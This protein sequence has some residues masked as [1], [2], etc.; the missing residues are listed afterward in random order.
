MVQINLFRP[1]APHL[2]PAGPAYDPEEDEPILEEAWPHLRIVYKFFLHFLESPSFDTRSAQQALSVT[3]L[4]QLLALF[5]SED[6]R[7]R[8]YLK[9]TLHRLYGRFLEYRQFIRQ[10][11]CNIFYTFIYETERHNGIAELLEILGTI[12]HGFALPLKPEHKIFLEKALLPLHKVRGCGTF[13]PQMAYCVFQFLEK[14]PTLTGSIFKS[15]LRFWP[16]VNSP[17]E[18]MFLSEIE[19]LLAIVIPE[20]IPGVL[21]P[22]FKRL[23]KCMGS[24]HFQ[25]AE[26]ALCLWRKKMF[27]K[28]TRRHLHV[29]LPIVYAPLYT[30]SK[31]HWHRVV[32]SMSLNALRLFMEMDTKLFTQCTEQYR[33]DFSRQTQAKED[34][35]KKWDELELVVSR[36]QKDDSDAQRLPDTVVNTKPAELG[37]S[38]A[39][40]QLRLRRK[41]LLP[42]DAQTLDAL[43]NHVGLAVDPSQDVSNYDGEDSDEDDESEEEDDETDDGSSQTDSDDTE[44]ESDDSD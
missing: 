19:E 39:H 22:L 27:M 17:K 15:I 24:P 21:A 37:S 33:R 14:D 25:V 10:N 31:Q 28:I 41:S 34:N 7:E 32:R 43:K 11:I 13:Y 6:P 20:Q 40:L 5:D 1:L 36:Q 38:E 2:N 3:W 4:E 8:D 35:G 42:I 18:L 30:N 29:I 26:K 16:A 44:D 9:T 23:A 12:I